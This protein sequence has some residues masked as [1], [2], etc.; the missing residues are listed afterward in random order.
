MGPVAIGWITVFLGSLCICLGI[1][2]FFF[3]DSIVTLVGGVVF[4]I[5]LVIFSGLSFH[6][7]KKLR[8]G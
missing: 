3:L 6:R 5:G 7:A 2:S 4:G 8:Q 1:A